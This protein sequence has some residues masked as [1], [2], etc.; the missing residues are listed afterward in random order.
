MPLTI[1]HIGIMVADLEA[2]LHFYTEVLG[3]QAG[4]GPQL[5]FRHLFA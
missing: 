1:D 5:T 4:P 3:L 2:A